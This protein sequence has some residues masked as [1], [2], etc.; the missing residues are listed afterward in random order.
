MEK[1]PAT[2]GWLW[3]KK[4]FALFRKQPVEI[5][6]LFL[7]YMFLM[8]TV[9]VIPLLGQLLPM[10]LLPVFSMAFMQA[11]VHIEQGK[12]V[13]PNVLLTGFRSPQLKSLIILGVLHL[14]VAIMVIGG[15][16][17]FDDGAL[18]Q[19]MTGQIQLDAKTAKEIDISTSILFAALFY[20]PFAM[21]FCYAAPLIAWKKM[22]VFQALFY[23]FFAVW[24]QF[25][26][27]M[28][29][30]LVWMAIGIILPSIIS[31]ISALLFNSPSI[32]VMLLLPLSL[33]MTVVLYCTF[34]QAYTDVFGVPDE[35]NGD[36][37][38]IV[39]N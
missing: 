15:S 36:S 38:P 33:L 26:A 21:A 13:F 7:A 28:T 4:G 24:T 29:Y 39:S 20:I 37:A 8:L 27:F 16:A 2:A 22:R 1:L 10:I 18:W 32:A 5:S 6:T 19:V 11:C 30:S 14:I 34:Y 23:S 17:L 25:K 35:A 9:G 3:I 31:L 12:R